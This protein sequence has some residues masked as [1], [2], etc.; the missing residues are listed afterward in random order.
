MT[1]YVTKVIKSFRDNRT[2]ALFL[3][4]PVKRMDRTLARQAQR[5]LEMIHAAET[6]Q[7]LRTVPGNRL[8]LLKGDRKGQRSIRVT[9][10][11]RIC[12]VWREDGAYDVEF[13][14]YHKG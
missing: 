3:G 2:L 10:Q 12:F 5:K 8:E 11:W 9:G 13:T 4:K 7:V 1:F 14:D 6:L